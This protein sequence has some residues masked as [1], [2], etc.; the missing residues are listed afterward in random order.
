VTENL[1]IYSLTIINA[2]VTESVYI[3][4]KYRLNATVF[5]HPPNLGTDQESWARCMPNCIGYTNSRTTLGSATTHVYIVF[6]A[7]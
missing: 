1:S 7:L 5:R 6:Q 3:R 4:A 2:V